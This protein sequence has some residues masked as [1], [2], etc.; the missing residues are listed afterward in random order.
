MGWAYIFGLLI[1]Y[2]QVFVRC[3]TNMITITILKLTNRCPMCSHLLSHSD[4]NY[5]L[6]ILLILA[7]YLHITRCP[8][9]G[10]LLSSSKMSSLHLVTED[11]EATRSQLKVIYHHS[12]SNN[13]ALLTMSQSMTMLTATMMM[14]SG[15]VMHTVNMMLITDQ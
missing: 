2:Y 13:D 6:Q 1:A 12:H 11:K 9:C 8:L 15:L 14:I 10:H 4:S 3:A 5:K 7:L